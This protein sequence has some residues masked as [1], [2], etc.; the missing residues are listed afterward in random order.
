MATKLS[1]L[2]KAGRLLKLFGWLAMI[3]IVGISSSILIPIIHDGK[4]DE[5]VYIA[6]P[7]IVLAVSISV[8]YLFIGNAVKK[9]KIWAKV[10]GIVLAGVSLFSFPIG[11]IIGGFILYYLYRGWN[12]QISIT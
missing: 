3:A 4:I 2:H 1:N 9:D 10:T 8:F 12:E 7:L 6:I 11:T 5:E